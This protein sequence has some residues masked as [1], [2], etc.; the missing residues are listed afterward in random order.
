MVMLHRV[1]IDAR[2]KSN[3]PKQRYAQCV[4]TSPATMDYTD[5]IR[6]NQVQLPQQRHAQ[7]CRTQS[8]S[9]LRHHL[10]PWSCCRSW[11]FHIQCCP[12]SAIG[13]TATRMGQLSYRDAETPKRSW[14]TLAAYIHVNDE[15]P[16]FQA[17]ITLDIHK[18]DSHTP[19]TNEFRLSYAKNHSRLTRIRQRSIKP[20]AHMLQID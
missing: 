4:A 3:L 18:P 14:S 2:I 17:S 8:S 7:S 5:K 20:D 1:L 15:F 16:T 19:K 13:T 9:V 6:D 10:P 11:Q 12:G